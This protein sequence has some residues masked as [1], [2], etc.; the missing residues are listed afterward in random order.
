MLAPVRK[1]RG[2]D[3]SDEPA[4]VSTSTSD[5]QLGGHGARPTSDFATLARL[6]A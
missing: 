4:A 5:P 3:E 2:P 1:L 6:R